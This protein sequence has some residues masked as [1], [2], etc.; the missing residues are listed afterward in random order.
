MSSQNKSA[1]FWIKNL[2]LVE[3]PEHKDGFFAVPFE[4]TFKVL[5]K[6]KVKTFLWDRIVKLHFLG[7]ETGC[8]YCI[9]SGE[10]DQD[11]HDQETKMF[12]C[13]STEMVFYH[14]GLPVSIY[15][16]TKVE[17][18]V[19]KQMVEY[20]IC[21]IQSD[22]KVSSTSSLVPRLTRDTC[23]PSPAPR[24]R[25]SR[26][27]WTPR[28]PGR[29]TRTTRSSAWCLP[30]PS[31]QMM[32]RPCHS[33]MYSNMESKSES[34]LNASTWYFDETSGNKKKEMFNHSYK[35]HVINLN[36]YIFRDY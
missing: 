14:A 34:E 16:V 25:G 29:G 3:H 2:N 35:S 1:E 7:R 5:N 36:R 8:F 10:K 27:V 12:M 26:G 32:S 6:N 15:I 33:G 23:Y 30:R 13:Q 24:T 28:T 11:V 20:F 22:Q 21:R 19:P 18:I 31:I 9:L 17:G 4:D